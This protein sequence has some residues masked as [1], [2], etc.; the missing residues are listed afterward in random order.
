MMNCKLQKKV[1]KVYLKHD[2]FQPEN[3]EKDLYL[4]QT[5]CHLGGEWK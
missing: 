5:C 3:L 4:L 1:I 2:G